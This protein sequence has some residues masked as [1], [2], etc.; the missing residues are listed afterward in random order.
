[1]ATLVLTAVGT[2]IGGPIGGAIG[3]FVGRQ[4]DQLI[5]APGPRTGP[6][7]KELSVTTSSYGQPLPRN[8][9]RMR[10]AGTV[11]WSTDLIESSRKEGGG[12]GQP[13]VR[14]YSYSASFAVA[15]SSTPI[16]RVGRI[17]ADGQLLRG[18]SG[19]L[20]S[21]GEMRTYLGTGDAEVDPLI[22]AD[23]GMSTPAF[24][25]CAYVVFEDLQLADFGNRIPALTFEIFA[26][27]DASV[28]LGQLVPTT[29]SRGDDFVLSGLR[30]FSDEGGAVGSSL[31]VIDQVYPLTCVTRSGGLDLASAELLPEEVI[32]LPEQLSAQNGESGPERNKQRG[33]TIGR[34]PMALRYYD[35]E[36][37]YQPGVQRAV[38][39]RPDGRE[40]MVDLPGTMVATD[41]RRIANSNANRARWKNE[42]T[43][44]RISELDPRL[45]P[46][47]ITTLPDKSGFWRVRS[48][49]WFDGGIELGIE[50]YAP[51]LDAPIAGVAGA[52]NA[53]ND[54]LATPTI[55]SAF[56]VP[57]DDT[58]SPGNRRI[59]AAATSTSSGWRGAALFAEQ[60]TSLVDAGTTGSRRAVT[61]QLLDSVG[62]SPGH[63]LEP[64]A[65]V[66]VE[67]A[68]SDLSFDS[69]D[70]VGIAMGENSLLIGG[71]VLQFLEANR[72]GEKSWRL[73]GLLRG[74]V[75]TEEAAIS[76]HEAGAELALLNDDLT[77]IDPRNLGPERSARLAAIGRGD[78]APVF[79]TIQNS[80]LS[81]RPPIPVLPRLHAGQDDTWTIR[82]TRRARGQW[83][84]PEGIEV[85][86]VEESETYLV[87]FGDCDTPAQ[88]WTV[89]EPNFTLT[90]NDRT[91]LID[92]FGIGSLWV[93]QSGT[94]GLSSPLFL[95]T[96]E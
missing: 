11:I 96:I 38:G 63:V 54:R 44:W 39:L 88:L 95:A 87:G 58:S 75:G 22:A 93:K 60:G 67:L 30:G 56:E 94:Y 70:V 3:A 18:A 36:R 40:N 28:S 7:L 62:G 10:V 81:L 76:G 12:K 46:G 55:L 85:P 25:D 66:N 53:P 49:E 23:K 84:W 90:Q 5:F 92:R 65:F 29:V 16:S 15:L 57:H 2:L 4:A 68:A 64:N 17:W 82:W 21:E 20:K 47:T 91:E 79:A 34:E 8:F 89:G 51:Q 48:W 6:R 43:S 13:S 72:T 71:E 80:G 78:D 42:T 61:G 1:M 74:R 37:D 86:L 73:S 33:R 26:D 19:D 24:R 52:I 83:R 50:R 35:E 69:T 45:S 27:D 14:T 31:A 59:F 77:N 41:A 9:G 32:A